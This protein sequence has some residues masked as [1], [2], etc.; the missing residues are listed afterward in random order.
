M[1]KQDLRKIVAAVR[2][3]RWD[4]GSVEVM[5]D[6]DD[7]LI[8]LTS[9]P[10]PCEIKY[11]SIPP[12]AVIVRFDAKEKFISHADIKERVKWTRAEGYVH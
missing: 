5:L 1:R 9:R 12:G 11:K 8:N 10:T 3:N 2:K 6:K 7:N 4:G